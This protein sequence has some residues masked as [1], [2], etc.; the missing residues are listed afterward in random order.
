MVFRLGTGVGSPDLISPNINAASAT[1][2]SPQGLALDLQGNLYFA[3]ADNHCVRV[4]VNNGDSYYSIHIVAGLK[5]R[6]VF[7]AQKLMSL[8][9]S[10]C[11]NE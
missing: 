5:K 11:F 7:S 2:N 6:F 1:L 10:L 3:D 9:L 8:K 4:I